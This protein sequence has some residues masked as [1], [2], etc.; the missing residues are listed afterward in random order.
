[1]GSTLFDLN[2]LQDS[3]RD[4]PGSV[5]E[6]DFYHASPLLP[7]SDEGLRQRALSVWLPPCSPV[8]GEWPA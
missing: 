4:E 5:I 8:R 2:A 6:L 7:M 1:M 3:Y